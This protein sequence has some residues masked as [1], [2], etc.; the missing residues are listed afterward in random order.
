MTMQLD[1]HTDALTELTPERLLL[2]LMRLE[3]TVQE[4]RQQTTFKDREIK[5]L[6]TQMREWQQVTLKLQSRVA[7][8]A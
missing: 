3:N 7:K 2:R 8:R 6:E 4:L 1:N 5:R